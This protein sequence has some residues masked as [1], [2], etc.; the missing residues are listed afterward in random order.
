MPLPA[1]PIVLSYGAV[2]VTAV[3]AARSM[4]RG[5]R[6]QRA[7]D[8]HD[9]TPEGLTLWKN[10]EQ[11]NGTGRMTRVFRLTSS[12]KGVEIDASAFG[13]IRVRRV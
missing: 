2:A 10:D 8:L 3:I 13:R 1:L 7:E 6:D 9:D 11:I 4:E 12:G 5:R